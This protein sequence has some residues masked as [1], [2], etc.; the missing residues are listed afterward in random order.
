MKPLFSVLIPTC[1]R[2]DLVRMCLASALEL[3]F[4]DCE[5][6]LSDNS[7]AAEASQAIASIAKRFESDSRFRFVKPPV[8]M[9]MA[10]HW[11]WLTAQA[12][13]RFIAILTDRHAVRPSTLNVLAIH[14]KEADPDLVVWNVRSGFSETS[15]FMRTD[16]F[17]GEIRVEEPKQILRDYLSL[18][19]WN[20]ESMFQ[21]NL[22][23]GLNSLYKNEIAA[24]IREKHGRLFFPLSPD[25]TSAFLLL[26]NSTTFSL[27]DL[28]FYTSFGNSS[29]GQK[30]STEGVNGYVS[31]Y[32]GVDPFEGCPT[33]VDCVINTLIRDFLAMQRIEGNLAGFEI[34]YKGYYLSLYNEILLK[35]LWGSP[36]NTI[37]LRQQWRAGVETLDQESKKDIYLSVDSL[38][39]KEVKDKR[40]RKFLYRN[41]LM[42][43][44]KRLKERLRWIKTIGN[45]QAKTYPSVLDAVTQTDDYL[46]SNTIV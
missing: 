2:P 28:P 38:R 35:E 5:I 19:L 16:K 33:R 42:P 31:T 40:L 36:L 14:L 13:G 24:R 1:N 22:P 3:K 4:D 46:N 27:V 21:Q 32:S 34:N 10:D 6:V 7:S 15:G 9:N 30:S 45:K 44:V 11:E 37:A 25:Y 23:R 8:H 18:S 20:K 12:T 41:N 43:V 29:N 39:G 26:S 17:T